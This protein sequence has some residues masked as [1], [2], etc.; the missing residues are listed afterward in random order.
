MAIGFK[1]GLMGDL[2]GEYVWF[3]VPIYGGMEKG[4]GN[5]LVME[6]AEPK[7]E[8]SGGKATYFL[9]IVSRQDYLAF[10]TVEALDAETDMLLKK[11]NRCMLDINFRREPIYLSD[12]RLEEADY[13]KYK[14]ALQRIP[15]LQ[16]LRRLYI[17][18]VIHSP[19]EQWKSDTME[20]LRFN[21]ATQDDA[22]R[23]KKE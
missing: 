10:R 14:I 13:V 3:L 5:A 1:R 12:E 22:I 6:A 21:L 9:K 19:P 20:L 23:W 2:T 11:I 17:G 7:S 16:L 15:S 18:R 4:Y 8:A